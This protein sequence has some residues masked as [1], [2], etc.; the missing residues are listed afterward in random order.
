MMK[1]VLCIPSLRTA[2]AEKFVVDLATNFKQDA[3]KI[4]IAVTRNNKIE[5]FKDLLNEKH[6]EI[7]DLSDRS[8]FKMLKKQIKFLKEIKP[9]VVHAN[10]GSLFHIMLA[11]KLVGTKVRLYTVH[12]EAKLLYGDSKIRKLFYKLA[13]TFFKFKPIAIC[14]TVKKT[15]VEEFG[16][17]YKNM[18]T[19]NNGVDINAFHTKEKNFNKDEIVFI[20][21]GTMYW[22]KN[23][24]Q[25][26]D[27]FHEISKKYEN[28]KL[29]LLGDGQDRK[30]LQK[31]IEEKNLVDLV[32]M[33][34]KVSNV[35]EY[36]RNADV[37]VSA[38]LTEG[39]PLSMLEAMAS[40]LPVITS[41]A[42]GSVDI[43]SSDVNGFV[44]EKGNTEDLINAMEILV[45]DKH[46]REIYSNNSRRIAESWSLDKCAEHYFNIYKKELK[47]E[48]FK[49]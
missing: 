48:N 2:G 21:T 40:G 33:P 27:A 42:G 9:D 47:N 16:L 18:Y 23:Q 15:M 45:K 26:I 46:C 24:G 11:T 28:V 31:Q 49:K 22:V 12:N 20:N 5:T 10:I 36:L 6:I 41:D 13:F 32:E 39:L 17:K 29:I 7:I 44:F 43:V 14:E 35:G 1:V 38:S 34:G 37:Y 25:I 3:M 4:Y 8:F 30:K 19:V